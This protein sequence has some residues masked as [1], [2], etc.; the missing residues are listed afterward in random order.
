MATKR[1]PTVPTTEAIDQFCAAFDDLFA[2][3]EERTALRQYLI[4][5]LLPREHNKTLV[6][7]GAIVPG[8]NRQALHHFM[9]D[10]PWDAEALNRRRLQQW[11]AHPYLG[12]HAGGVLSVDETGD[13][14]RGHRIVLAAQQYLGKLGHVAN[15][16]A[17]VTS[18]W[19][20]GSR[21]VPLGVKAYRPASRLPQG[22]TDP[23]F[24]TKPQLAWQLIE[25]ARAADIPF[26]LVVA[27]SIY[28]ENADVEAKRFGAQ[29]PY[30]LGLKPSHGTW[31]QVGDPANP[32]AF[33]P[34]AA[35]ARFPLEAWQRTVRFD[36]HGK[37]LVRYIAELELGTAYGPTKGIRLIAATLDPRRLTPE[38]TW[39]LA[40]ALPLA[41]VSAEQVDEIYRL[42]DW[43]EHY[44][45]PVKHELGWADY[46]LRPERAIVR[47]WQLVMLAYTFSLLVGAVPALPSSPAGTA[48]GG[49]I[50][51]H[52]RHRVR[53]AGRPRHL[54]PGITPGTRVAV[55]LGAAAAR[56]ATLV[57]RRP[58][59][60]AGRAPRPRR[61]L[62]AA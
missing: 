21:H 37:E 7:L 35:A 2:R 60:R 57:A 47:H 39:Y 24:Q 4:G 8:A 53:G 38:S 12:P 55:P 26:R 50:G 56:V 41:Q 29:I 9:H 44:Y 61:V 45:T 20:D 11:Q 19:A 13:P 59:A 46:Q 3:Y 42:R 27:D 30:I 31:Q 48:A 5:L 43:I 28:G 33:T 54:E 49:K 23:D 62:P 10:A 51:A 16:V 22:R 40:T 6:E 34:A 1:K 36:S 15:G 52:Q 58:A 18:Q 14:K 25:E 17:A 32:P